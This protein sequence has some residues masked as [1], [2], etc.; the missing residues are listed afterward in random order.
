MK[1]YKYLFIILVI[2][3]KTGNVLSENTLFHV[4][5][6]EIINETSKGYKE[7]A[8]RAI[9]K[10]FK[11][12]I[13]RI[14]LKNDV[15]KLSNLKFIEIKELV[16]YYQ[17]SEDNKDLKI[18]KVSYNILFDKEKL[19]EL[20]Y[21]KKIS[22]S[23]ISNKEL[24]ILPILKKNDQY[25]IYN[26][27]FF[28]E[29]WNEINTTDLIEF[30]LPIENIEIIKKI[31]ETKDNLLNINIINLFKEYSDQ[32]LAL[33]LIENN[34]MH[35]EKIFL[36]TKIS[37]KTFNK[38]ILVKKNNLNQ[39]KFYEKIISEVK[40]EII[41]IVKSQ[42]LVDISTPS[43]LNTKLILNKKNNLFELYKRLEKIDLIE[44]IYVKEL[45]NE[46]VFLK[47]KYLGKLEKLIQKL[48]E[49]MVNL[50]FSRNEWNI[51]IK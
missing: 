12:L 16:S 1:L 49:Q 51:K 38:N 18:N 24:Y 20:F 41:N 30:V 21:K 7:T 13:K 27:N 9:K 28:Y 35:Q 8:D 6:I 22:Y 50:K 26:Q 11:E 29:K 47:I 44:N 5:N 39:E 2:F 14:L 19:H 25:F 3:F 46:Y 48:N 4:N 43:F 31:N 23:D 17:I 15:K 34:N 40:D 32:N 45:N 10:G 37:G 42:N 33:I 36:K